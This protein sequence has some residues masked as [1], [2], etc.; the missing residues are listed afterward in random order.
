MQ[1]PITQLPATHELFTRER[2][3]NRMRQFL[4]VFERTAFRS[5]PQMPEMLPVKVSHAPSRTSAWNDQ[6]G[7]EA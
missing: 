7:R 2:R 5:L 6:A 1:A 4:E 3:R